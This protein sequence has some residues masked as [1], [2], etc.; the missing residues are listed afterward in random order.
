MVEG[1]FLVHIPSSSLLRPANLGIIYFR[2][3]RIVKLVGERF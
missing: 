2:K 3:M 1:L